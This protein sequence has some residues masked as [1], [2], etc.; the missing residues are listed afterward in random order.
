MVN[1]FS[2]VIYMFI[3]QFLLLYLLYLHLFFLLLH[4]A[5]PYPNAIVIIIIA[6]TGPVN[7]GIVFVLVITEYDS[8][9]AIVKVPHLMHMTCT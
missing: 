1:V 5:N 6:K 8:K 9:D 3:L 2:T 7:D 4:L